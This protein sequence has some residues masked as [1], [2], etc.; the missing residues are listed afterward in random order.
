[1]MP[2]MNGY[3]VLEHLKSDHALRDIPVI[4]LSALDEIGSVVRCIELGAEELSAQAIRS[5]LFTRAYRRLPG[6][7]TFARSGNSAP[8]RVGGVEQDVGAAR[9]RAGGTARQTQPAQALF[10]AS[11]RRINCRRRRRGPLKT[12]RREVTVVFLDLRA[13]LPSPKPLSPRK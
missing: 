4:V 2:E 11:A 8:E 1:M 3:Q 5:G 9:S 7:E 13:S 12:H 6:E 10:L